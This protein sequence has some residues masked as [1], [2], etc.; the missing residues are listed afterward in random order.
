MRTPPYVA[1]AMAK[2]R[3][4]AWADTVF[5]P[6]PHHPPGDPGSAKPSRQHACPQ[7][8]THHVFEVRARLDLPDGRVHLGQRVRS[9]PAVRIAQAGRQRRRA[10]PC[11][12]DRRPDAPLKPG[13]PACEQL[14][15]LHHGL[16]A[17]CAGRPSRRGP[18]VPDL[19]ER[20]SRARHSLAAWGPH[21]P[22]SQ[23]GSVAKMR[24]RNP[25]RRKRYGSANVDVALE[26]RTTSM[27]A[28]S[29]RSKRGAQSWNAPAMRSCPRSS[30]RTS[31]GAE[32]G[33]LTTPGTVW[34]RNCGTNTLSAGRSSGQS[35]STVTSLAR[36]RKHPSATRVWESTAR[37]MAPFQPAPGGQCMP[38]PDAMTRTS[39]TRARRGQVGRGRRED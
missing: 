16:P 23:V 3:G 26:M 32:P 18:A 27:A 11:N 29:R 30:T 31:S 24:A 35:S 28:A 37:G 39:R 33:R 36:T 4:A 8:L 14:H 5:V 7:T 25:G 2:A 1:C 21:R 20:R 34:V 10:P 17:F 22:S 15:E 13:R 38:G 9:H 19:G 6:P 12:V